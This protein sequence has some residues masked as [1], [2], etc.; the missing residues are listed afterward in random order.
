MTT[1]KS[2]VMVKIQTR[3]TSPVETRSAVILFHEHGVSA[4]KIVEHLEHAI[5][6]STV[7]RIIKAHRKAREGATEKKERKKRITK[8]E[9]DGRILQT[10]MM[11]HVEQDDVV[12]VAAIKKELEL[13]TT[14]SISS[15]TVRLALKK[16][17]YSYKLGDKRW[18]EC[19]PIREAEF[20]ANYAV[21]VR[22]RHAM[23]D[24]VF[25]D[26]TSFDPHDSR[27]YSWFPAGQ[28]VVKTS[29]GTHGKRI[30]VC[31]VLGYEGILHRA[32]TTGTY[33]AEDFMPVLHKT[34]SLIAGQHKVLVLDNARSHRTTDT[35]LYER[36]S[37]LYGVG[38][39]FLP[40]YAPHLNP[41]ELVFGAIKRKLAAIKPPGE[42]HAEYIIR[43]FDQLHKFFDVPGAYRHCG[44]F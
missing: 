40:G 26:E 17:G 35:T 10:I 7:R 44:F 1:S 27:R 5:S 13:A 41:I 20:W 42:N 34:L 11:R 43:L 28:H 36:L 16:L 8:F 33:K 4:P 39:I 12:T 14:T 32:L 9:R 29:G 2:G 19:S 18:K 22:A 24:L 21:Y 30:S 25:L 37:D 31:A 3:M 15:E 6:I 38:F 23:T